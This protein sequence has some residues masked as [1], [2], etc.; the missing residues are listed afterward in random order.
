MELRCPRCNQLSYTNLSQE[1]VRCLACGYMDYKIP[2]DVLRE[3]REGEG[4]KG[5]GTTYVKKY[6]IKYW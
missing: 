6:N 2:E 4:K 3:V 1:G 5:S